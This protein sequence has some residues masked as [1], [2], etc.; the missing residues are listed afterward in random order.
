MGGQAPSGV[1]ASSADRS[2]E[3]VQAYFEDYYERPVP[4]DAVRHVLAGHPLTPEIAGALNPNE[5]VAN[6]GS[7]TP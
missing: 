3:A 4:L 5:T 2:P 1:A 7:P 6:A